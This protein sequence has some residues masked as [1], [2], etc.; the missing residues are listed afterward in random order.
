MPLDPLSLRLRRSLGCRAGSWAVI[1]LLTVLPGL[2][3]AS[4]ATHG[5]TGA[6]L[7]A[8]SAITA[9]DFAA[10]AG[11][12][13]R[14][15]QHD[16]ENPML[17]ENAIIAQIAM[18]NLPAALEPALRMESLE[19]ASQPGRLA[20]IGNLLVA[21]A[22]AEAL[23]AL[24]DGRGAGPLIDPLLRGWTSL[25]MGRMTPALEAF[26]A[27]AQTRGM[28]AFGFYH[29]ALALAHA[30]DL[31]GAEDILSGA[32]AGPLPLTRRGVLARVQIL[33]QLDRAEEAAALM[34]ASF[35][36]APDPELD[37]LRSALAAGEAPAFDIIA[38][39]RD[40]MAE[41]FFDIANALQGE[42]ADSLTL[43]LARMAQALRPDHAPATLLAARLLSAMDQ[44]DL[45][46]AAY[47]TVTQDMPMFHLAE[48]GR[49]EALSRS[50]DTD[51]GRAVLEALAE[52]RADL[53]SVQIA[54]GDFLRRERDFDAARQAYDR[55][56]ALLGTPQPGHWI[57]WYS[58]AITHE[59]EDRWPEAEADFRQAL[60]LNPD[61]PH[62]LNYLGYTLVERREKLDE[63]LDMIERAVA[64]EPENGYIIDSLGWVFFR[65]GRY[66][67]ALVQ[68]ERAVELLPADPILNDHL[69]DVY[70]ALGRK[71]EAAF[72]WRRAL[73]FGP[74]DD[75]DMERIRRKLDIGL[76][77]VLREEGADPL[78][79]ASAAAGAGHGN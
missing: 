6:Y 77:R 74:A 68:M 76:D 2:L 10:A 41:V 59:R 45:A 75:L 5:H 55:A 32:V 43:M 31:E 54:L 39:P 69:G 53:P 63:A 16:P 65:L 28:E 8:R 9:N 19:L 22:H 35:G 52:I 7:S 38:R 72:Q 23:D 51:A 17:L 58:R 67:E 30:G 46:A 57:V 33:S 62:V 78:H 50:G 42:A 14:V 70:W 71:R 29:K 26:D 25:A 40:G 18:G 73:S 20:V 66:E 36:E 64:G 37:A 12:L 24:Q 27:L 11:Y 47:A 56:I 4:A 48:I 15:L 1:A 49:S 60:S 3:P 61:Q 79:P 34:A 13:D 21:G 44:H